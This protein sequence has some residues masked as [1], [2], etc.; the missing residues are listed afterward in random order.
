[1]ILLP[2]NYL[3]PIQYL[4][5]FLLNKPIQI[6]QEESF[7][8]QTY[9]NRC[10]ILGANGILTLSIPIKK[11]SGKKIKTKDVR[12]SYETNWQ[13][14]HWQSICSAYNH[15]P[16]FEFYKE[17]FLPFY[18]NKEK[19]LIDLNSKLIHLLIKLLNIN[20]EITFTSSFVKPNDLLPEV[21]DYRD[22]IH[23]KKEISDGYFSPVQY[24]QVFNDRFNFVENLSIIDLLFNE[25]PNAG[26]ILKQSIAK[27]KP[28]KK[29]L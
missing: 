20:T 5:K 1:M 9:R 16:F 13:S 15:S 24:I 4:T 18:E 22:S 19:Y 12:I 25:G 21:M 14:N 8:K 26:S 29:L 23:P 7:P 28:E 6:E 3:A 11:E 10:K 17:D 2:T 27:K